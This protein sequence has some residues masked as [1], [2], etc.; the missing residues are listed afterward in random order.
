MHS[1][2]KSSEE[3]VCEETPSKSIVCGEMLRTVG[4]TAGWRKIKHTATR[5]LWVGV[6]VEAK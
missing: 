1:G 6:A 4:N 5:G 3:I 2:G